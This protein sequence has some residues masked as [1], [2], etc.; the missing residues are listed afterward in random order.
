MKRFFLILFFSF[1]SIDL[2]F[3][4][5]FDKNNLGAYMRNNRMK[6]HI[7]IW[8]YKNVKENFYFK[9]NYYGFRGNDI[10]LSKIDAIILG[11]STIEERFKPEKFTITEYLNNKVKENGYTFAITNAGV[12]DQS[13]IGHVKNFKNW[14]FKLKDFSPKIILFY[15]GTY[16]T[17]FLGKSNE[18]ELDSGT[19]ITR[20]KNEIYYDNIKS[21]SFFYD[22]IRFL[23]YKFRP[24]RNPI[25]IDG[26]SYNNEKYINYETAVNNYDVNKL[27][28]KYKKNILNYLKRIDKLYEYSKKLNSAPIFI[29]NIHSRGYLEDIFILN[30]SLISHCKKESYNC[31]DLARKLDS[32][33]NYWTLEK[34]TT[35][36]GA[37]AIANIIM[38][39][40]K[41]II[42]KDKIF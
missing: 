22:K 14:F 15:V 39:D 29:T 41:K 27:S 16:D 35:E 6:N 3:G 20:E 32:K 9:R 21:R 24:K 26:N 7:K 34:H 37:K 12:Q 17:K 30:Y 19:A 23:K 36:I 31:I 5:W 28:L 40:L 18:E 25:S 2:I 38:L 8:E 10:K 1:I 42:I 13:T 11:G 4:G 33:P